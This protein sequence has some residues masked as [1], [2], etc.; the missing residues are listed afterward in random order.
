MRFIWTPEHRD[1]N[2]NDEE[3]DKAA[4]NAIIINL[5]IPNSRILSFRSLMTHV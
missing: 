2:G 4:R 1:I 5:N 3:A